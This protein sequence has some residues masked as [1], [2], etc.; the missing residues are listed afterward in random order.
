MSNIVGVRNHPLS[1]ASILFSRCCH[2]RDR[3]SRCVHVL[4]ERSTFMLSP[5]ATNLQTGNLARTWR[6]VSSWELTTP[7]AS[8]PSGEEYSLQAKRNDGAPV[9]T[10]R[11]FQFLQQ[12]G[13]Q[14]IGIDD[15]F[16]GGQSAVG[17]YRRTER[18]A[19]HRTGLV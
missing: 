8:A 14:V 10:L 19:R 18:A 15:H 9:K 11:L 2:K 13:F 1:P 7:F 3:N 4:I 5:P 17:L 6:T 16:A 12:F